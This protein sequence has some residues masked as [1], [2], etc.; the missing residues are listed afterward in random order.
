MKVTL[1]IGWRR[2]GRSL[3]KLSHQTKEWWNLFSTYR[4]SQLLLGSIHYWYVTWN[5]LSKGG[6]WWIQMRNARKLRQSSKVKGRKFFP[7]KN[8]LKILRHCC[9]ILSNKWIKCFKKKFSFK[10]KDIIWVW[11]YWYKFTKS[12][13]W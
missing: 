3:L 4:S 7:L 2:N 11:S 12:Y 1:R 10:Y 13:K 6:E 8:H 5:W 9:R